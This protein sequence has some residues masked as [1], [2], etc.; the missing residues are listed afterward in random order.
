VIPAALKLAVDL[1]LGIGLALLIELAVS[2]GW[3]L[4]REA[5]ITVF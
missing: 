2:R 4:A 3:R 1:A 5:L